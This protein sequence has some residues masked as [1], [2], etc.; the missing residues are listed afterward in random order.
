MLFYPAASCG[1]KVGFGAP[2]A[3]TTLEHVAVVEQAVKH[4]ADGG[5]VAQQFAPV[6]HR[7][8]AAAGEFV[9]D[10]PSALP[11][12]CGEQAAPARTSVH[13]AKPSIASKEKSGYAA[14][15][16]FSL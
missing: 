14:S 8:V 1:G 15:S 2:A 10:H 4:S 7:T 16:A 13:S 5:R 9:G 12:C 6:F 11:N 3:R